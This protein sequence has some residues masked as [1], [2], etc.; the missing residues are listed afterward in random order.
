MDQLLSC[1]K[2]RPV[3]LQTSMMQNCLPLD[4]DAYAFGEV[5]MERYHIKQ[6]FTQGGGVIPPRTMNHQFSIIVQGVDIWAQLSRWVAKGARRAYHGPKECPWISTSSWGIINHE[7]KHWRSQ[8]DERVR[9]SKSR[10]YAHLNRG[11]GEGFAF[12]NLIY[13]LWFVSP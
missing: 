9:Y 13:Y 4:E 10:L 12:I 3:T 11:C 6:A 8:Q 5:P 2:N 1:G 7:L